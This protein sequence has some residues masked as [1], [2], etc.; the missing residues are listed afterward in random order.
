MIHIQEGRDVERLREPVRVAR[1]G[2]VFGGRAHGIRVPLIPGRVRDLGQ[3]RFDVLAVGREAVVARD[4][5]HD[6]AEV[7]QMCQNPDR[8]LRTAAGVTLRF[9]SDGVDQ[10]LAGLTEVVAAA[11]LLDD[12]LLYLPG[13]Q[14]VEAS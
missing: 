4:R 9:G 3:D 2:V 6:V 1:R 12:R 7:A 5:I 11:L 13:S 10:W 8:A 14:V